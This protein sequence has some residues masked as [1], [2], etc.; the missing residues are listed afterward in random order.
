MYYTKEGARAGRAQASLDVTLS[1]AKAEWDADGQPP[2]SGVGDAAYSSKRGDLNVLEALKGDT[3]VE[4]AVGN[5]VTATDD[6]LKALANLAFQRLG[7]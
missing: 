3:K 4:L 1:G 5:G 7:V 2:V 6:Q